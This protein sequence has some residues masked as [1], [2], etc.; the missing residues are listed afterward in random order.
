MCVSFLSL[1][2]SL[3]L[4]RHSQLCRSAFPLFITFTYWRINTLLTR[5]IWPYNG[6][7]IVI[8]FVKVKLVGAAVSG[9][10]LDG[11]G[12]WWRCVA[13]TISTTS[14]KRQP[15]RMKILIYHTQRFVYTREGTGN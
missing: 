3:S 9:H 10:H 4:S 13:S 7:P 15:G 14:T 2:L 12:F 6:S 11:R 5:W 8:L 1:T